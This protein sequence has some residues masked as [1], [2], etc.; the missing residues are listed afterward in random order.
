MILEAQEKWE[1][2]IAVLESPLAQQ[3]LQSPAQMM[4]Y[5]ILRLR[6][7]AGN[8]VLVFER[9]FHALETE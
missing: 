5:R 9:A 8:H 6:Q 2:A 3:Y 7:R 4:F 1:E